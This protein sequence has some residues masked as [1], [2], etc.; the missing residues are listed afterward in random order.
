MTPLLWM[1]PDPPHPEIPS[2]RAVGGGVV[3]AVVVRGA[4]AA[5]E[6]IV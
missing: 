3:V 1:T 6:E 5:E 4:G 2:P